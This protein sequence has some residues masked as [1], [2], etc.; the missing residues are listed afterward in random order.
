[1]LTAN[2]LR[3]KFEQN[4]KMLKRI[5]PSPAERI[6]KR[7][8]WQKKYRQSLVFHLISSNMTHEWNFR[9]QQGRLSGSQQYN[10][11]QPDQVMNALNAIRHAQEAMVPA[12]VNS[13]EQALQRVLQSVH[14]TPRQQHLNFTSEMFNGYLTDR[15]APLL[16][17]RARSLA[18]V[19]LEL[20]YFYS[21]IITPINDRIRL[22]CTL[23]LFVRWR[24][25][26]M[27]FLASSISVS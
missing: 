18:P 25:T 6:L 27:E 16:E 7:L 15:L 4:L 17:E 24:K 3:E 1:M 12:I 11:Q 21:I 9:S 14:T 20:R 8:A 19:L 5:T 10:T 23:D 13:F 26:T 22:T 2:V